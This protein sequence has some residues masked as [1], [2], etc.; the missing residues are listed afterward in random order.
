[1][2]FHPDRVEYAHLEAFGRTMTG[3]APWLALEDC[4]EKELQTEWRKLC[5][6]CMDKATNP[7]SLDYMNF[8]EG[9]GQALVDAA[10]LAHAIVRAPKQLYFDL[11]ED[12]KQNVVKALKVTRKFVPFHCNWLF[13][14]A[15]I[16]TAFYVMG[17]ESDF[18]RI[19]YAVHSFMDWYKGDGTYGDGEKFHWDY[20]NS[21]VIQPMFVDIMRILKDRNEFYRT[22][23]QTVLARAS[24][25]AAIQEQLVNADGS[26][27]VFGRSVVYR[28]GAFQ[29]LS[30]AV[31]EG[32]LPKT[33]TNGQ[34][35]SALTAVIKKVDESGIYDE[36]GFLLPGI[37]GYQPSLA[38]DYICVGSLY[39]C[40]AVF[41]PLGLPASHPFWTEEE[42]AWTNQK[43]WSGQDVTVDH[44]ID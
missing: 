40:E 21:F 1:M 5:Q 14:S 31:L 37:V 36:N 19:E 7:S 10:F 27:P 11:K 35:R 22:T 18:T 42:Q 25:Y 16:E 13:F 3:L 39:L 4:P 34:V 2:A 9:Y 29:A 15:M 41:L 44:A 6:I 12:V 30:Q 8:D 17:E 20:Y 26:Y 24:R 32:Y 28:Y 43:I 33:L 38:E 23:Y